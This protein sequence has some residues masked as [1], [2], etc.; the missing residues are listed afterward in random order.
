V[1]LE[2]ELTGGITSRRG[3]SSAR[4]TSQGSPGVLVTRNS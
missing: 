3:K 4:G 2:I 1:I